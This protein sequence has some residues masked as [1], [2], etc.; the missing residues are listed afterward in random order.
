MAHC[1]VQTT[2]YRAKKF[3]TEIAGVAAPL[4]TFA[5][6]LTIATQFIITC[7][8]SRLEAL[9]ALAS[10]FF[11]ASALGLFLI[12]ILLYGLD[13]DDHIQDQR[14]YLV[15]SQLLLVA[16]FMCV[17]FILL[18]V[19][20]MVAGQRDVGI[21]GIALMGTI[22]ASFITMEA[23]ILWTDHGVATAGYPIP[24]NDLPPVASGF[25]WFWFG[26][27]LVVGCIMLGLG[28]DA[29]A[30][31]TVQSGCTPTIITTYPWPTPVPVTIANQPVQAFLTS[32]PISVCMGRCKW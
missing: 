21:S 8:E 14:R 26:C 16:I 3:Y 11:L 22:V 31:A 10:Q 9:L 1:P 2:H 5:G 7:P 29:A 32:T 24:P 13:E 19:A 15:F 12:Y 27:E 30:D 18:A 28:A 4:A 17:A 6:G 25:L 23:S 20:I